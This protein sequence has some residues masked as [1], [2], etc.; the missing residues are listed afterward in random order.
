MRSATII[1]FQRRMRPVPSPVLVGLLWWATSIQIVMLPL[2]V[3]V[4]LSK[5]EV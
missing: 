3:A 2:T 1:P 4:A 5:R